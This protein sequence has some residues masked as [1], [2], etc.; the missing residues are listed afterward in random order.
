MIFNK[1]CKTC[2]IKYESQARNKQYCNVCKIK[3]IKIKNSKYYQK[4]KSKHHNKKKKE[5]NNMV[6]DMKKSIIES[7]GGK[8]ISDLKKNEAQCPKCF[9]VYEMSTDYSLKNILISKEQRKK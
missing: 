8:F 4:T 1:I 9:K 3:R 2:K 6:N 7:C 5:F